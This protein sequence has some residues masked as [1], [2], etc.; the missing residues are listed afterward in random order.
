MFWSEF[1]IVEKDSKINGHIKLADA[2]GIQDKHLQSVKK[3]D[4]LVRLVKDEKPDLLIIDEGLINLNYIETKLLFKNI[5]PLV[6]VFI[7]RDNGTKKIIELE[8][9]VDGYK[10]KIISEKELL[11]KVKLLKLRTKLKSSRIHK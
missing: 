2:L 4:E 3:T 11:H 9:S 7:E 10:E 6:V 8:R 1:L 5:S